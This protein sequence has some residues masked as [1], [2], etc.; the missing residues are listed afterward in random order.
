MK[1]LVW[2]LGFYCPLFFAAK[3]LTAEHDLFGVVDI[4]ATHNDGI[5]SYV[6][7]G[8][9][10]FRSNPDSQLSLSQLGLSYRVEWDNNMSAHLVANGY[11]DGVEDGLGITEA[12]I[13]Y[14]GLPSEKGVRISA[15]A[16]IMYPKIS[17]ENVATAWSSPY[18]LS[19]STM[20]AWLGEEVRHIGARLNVDLLGKF[21]Q[22]NHDVSFNL[23]AFSNNDTTGAMLSWH[24][25]TLSSRQTLWQETL[26]ITTIPSMNGGLLSGQAK[27]SDPFLELDDR[28][29]Y[30]GSVN[31]KMKGKGLVQAGYYNN[32]ADTRIAIK[33]QYAW[34]T[35]FIHLGVKW[36]LPYRI[37]LISQYMQGDTLMNAPEGFAV[38]DNDYHSAYM[39]FSRR[40]D[41]HRLSFR[42]EDF[43][44]DDN[45]PTPGDNN[46]EDG[47]AYTLSYNYQF[48]RGWFFHIEYNRVDSTRYARTYLGQPEDLVEQQ[49]QLASRYYF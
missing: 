29:G 39:M 15:R 27:E 18:T 35:R 38:V 8:L 14:K 9:G 20:N 44:V 12:F 49:W 41:K 7:G 32:D 16:G 17:L 45:D 47:Q 23:E 11:W 6:D 22:S 4:R 28:L 25:W 2:I 3:G 5:T 26:P 19:Y 24:G 43:S 37:E 48:Q 33:G 46:N 42:L 10:K 21:R 36:R 40:W 31:W 34:L 1:K 30:H 13:E